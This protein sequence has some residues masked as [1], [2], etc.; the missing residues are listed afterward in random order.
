[1]NKNKQKP[2]RGVT[3]ECYMGFTDDLGVRVR[4]GRHY[5]FIKDRFET[6]YYMYTAS[7]KGYAIAIP[8]DK[9]ESHFIQ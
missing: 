8:K 5:I 4:R 3:Y 1:M 9:F 6:F 7:G 2:Q